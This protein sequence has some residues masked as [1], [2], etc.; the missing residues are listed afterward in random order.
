MTLYMVGVF[1]DVANRVT[2]IRPNLPKEWKEASI[3]NLWIDDNKINISISSEAN[4]ITVEVTQTQKKAGISIE[5]P[6]EYSKVKVLGK[7]VSNDTKDGLRRILM[8]GD[9]VKIEAVKN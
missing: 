5:L 1:V 2:Y 8:T 6:A 3:E 7:E 4:Q 9:H